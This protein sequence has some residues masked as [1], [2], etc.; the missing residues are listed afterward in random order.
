MAPG[1]RS[2][3]S[4]ASTFA[5]TTRDELLEIIGNLADNTGH[6]PLDLAFGAPLLSLLTDDE[7]ALAT[8]K[9]YTLK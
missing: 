3:L 6:A 5:G 4:A 1:F 9:N 7:I 8:A 2:G